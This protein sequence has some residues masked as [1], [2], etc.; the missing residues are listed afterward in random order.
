MATGTDAFTKAL[1]AASAAPAPALLQRLRG[2]GRARFETLGLPNRRQEA[3]RQTRLKGITDTI[4]E[5]PL[6]SGAARIDTGGWRRP[7]AHLLV[8]V[9]GIHSPDLSVVGKLPDGVVVSSLLTAAATGSDLVERHLGSLAPLNGH[10]FAALNTALLADGA[11]LWVPAGVTV[12]EPIQLVFVTAGT[13]RPT[14]VAPR[15][16]IIAGEN[17]RLT[18]EEHHAGGRAL[19]LS[20]PVTEIVIGDNA[21]VEHVVV[22]DESRRTSHLAVRHARLCR[23][24]RYTAQALSIGADLARSDIQVV[25]DGEGAEATLDGLYLTNGTQQADSHLTVRHARPHCVSHQLYKGVL[26]GRSRSVFTGR[27]VVDQD[28]QKTDARQS[29]RNLILSDAAVA[30]SNPQLEIFADDVRC[31]HG[32]TIGRLDKDALFYMQARGIGRAEA[33]QLLIRA[34]TG[35]ILDRI[36]IAPLREQLEGRVG[37]WL[38]EVVTAGDAR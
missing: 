4:F 14:V 2:E 34:F 16:L 18:V 36:T 1:D 28:A 37:S 26:G 31:T 27:I 20:C 6:A 13:D 32:S 33:R 9:D 10:P 25:L 24:A 3:W 8:F 23:D 30:N 19:S 5:A 12:E 38:T 17:S 35:E 15:I 11:V 29:N 7:G 21:S 22:Q